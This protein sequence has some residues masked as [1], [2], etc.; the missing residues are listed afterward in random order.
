MCLTFFLLFSFH[1]FYTFRIR[2]CQAKWNFQFLSRLEGWIY[3]TQYSKRPYLCS[4]KHLSTSLCHQGGKIASSLRIKLEAYNIRLHKVKS[5]CCCLPHEHPFKSC[6]YSLWLT[7]FTCKTGNNGTYL[8]WYS[9]WHDLIHFSSL[10]IMLGILHL[11]KEL[12]GGRG[13]VGRKIWGPSIQ[14]ICMHVVNN[15][16]T[17]L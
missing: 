5:W 2:L 11:S 14:W 13:R 1:S 7:F 15:Y 4:T 6:L 8:V 3:L 16:I 10:P 12:W 9:E 17:A